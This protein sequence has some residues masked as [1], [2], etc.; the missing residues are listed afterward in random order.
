MKIAVN[1]TSIL[2][3]FCDIGLLD[4]LMVIELEMHTTDFVIAEIEKPEQHQKVMELVHTGKLTVNSF[5]S[6]ELTAIIQKENEHSG[7]SLT[8]CSV[9]HFAE[10]HNAIL[11]TGDGRLRKTTQK[12]GLD[13][14]GSLW[15]LDELLGQGIISR[16]RACHALKALMSVNS[17][18]PQG[19]CEKRLRNWC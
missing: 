14:H 11:L 1:D 4:Q 18:L 15:L 12:A 10:T 13:V 17:R 3:D 8:D 9:W 5:T 16:Q 2:I 19:E 7:L 6:A